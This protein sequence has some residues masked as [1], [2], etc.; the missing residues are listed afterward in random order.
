MALMSLAKRSM[1]SHATAF[2]FALAAL[3]CRGDLRYEGRSVSEWIDALAAPDTAEQKRAASALGRILSVHPK[4]PRAVPALVRAISDT[5]DGVRMTAARALSD[6]EQGRLPRDAV[7]GVIRALHDTAHAEVRAQA[8]GL[9]GHVPADEAPRVVAEL[10]EAAGNSAADVRAAAVMAL[11]H[12]GAPAVAVGAPAVRRA[13]ADSDR[14]VHTTAVLALA[15]L[16]LAPSDGDVPLLA[17]ALQEKPALVREKAAS[18]LAR[19]RDVPAA[20]IWD[21]VRT[22]GDPEPEVR[23][24]AA[25]ALGQLAGRGSADREHVLVHLRHRLRDSDA[26]VRDEARKALRRLGATEDGE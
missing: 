24:A 21:L 4:T 9:L 1:T 26:T 22:L 3:G 20:V 7:P 14:Y 23:R 16:G 17:R 11:E 5:N 10:A 2:L 6:V 12:I 19:G 13:L 18:A 25:N 15:G 8:A